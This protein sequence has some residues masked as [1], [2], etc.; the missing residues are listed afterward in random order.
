MF[1][2]GDAKWPG[3][4]KLVEECGELVQVCGK[5]MG[6]RGKV[7][8]RDGTHLA[9]RLEE[10]IGDVLA[11]IDFVIDHSG[12]SITRRGTQERYLAKRALFER[13]HAE[14]VENAPEGL[15]IRAMTGMCSRC[16]EYYYNGE[17]RCGAEIEKGPGSIGCCGGHVAQVET[18]Q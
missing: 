17:T 15:Q 2:I 4:S 12:R 14:D 1:A 16:G 10:E 13:W 7:E 9:T 11:A 6:T 8:H 5:L 18:G 3:I